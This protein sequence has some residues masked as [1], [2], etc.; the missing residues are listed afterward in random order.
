M[1]AQRVA[2]LAGSEQPDHPM[3]G[4]AGLHLETEAFQAVGHLPG[5]LGI[6]E[7]RFG[8]PVQVPA[9]GNHLLS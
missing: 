8:N 7:A 5:R 3:R 9:G 1:A 4:D 6:I 2:G